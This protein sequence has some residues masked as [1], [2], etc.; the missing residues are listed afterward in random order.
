MGGPDMIAVVIGMNAAALFAYLIAALMM[1]A[2]GA[3]HNE[4]DLTSRNLGAA[5]GI[6]MLV[7]GWLMQVAAQV[8]I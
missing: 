2:A 6:V 1:I 4:G 3:C 7:F 8:I 5:I